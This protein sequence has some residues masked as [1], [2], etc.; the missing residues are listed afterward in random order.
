MTFKL[1]LIL[2]VNIFR[3][4]ITVCHTIAAFVF[5]HQTVNPKTL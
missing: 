5:P 2:T 1:N 3:K 4:I